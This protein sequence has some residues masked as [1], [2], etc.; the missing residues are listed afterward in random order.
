VL[1][2]R[3]PRNNCALELSLHYLFIAGGIGITPI[4]PMIAGAERADAE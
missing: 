2:V 3:G 4:L 1:R